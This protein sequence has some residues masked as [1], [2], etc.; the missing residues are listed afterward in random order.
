MTYSKC[1]NSRSLHRSQISEDLRAMQARATAFPSKRGRS[2]LRRARRAILG[3]L[4]VTRDDRETHCASNNP[5]SLADRL[6]HTRRDLG[7]SS[8][9]T[10]SRISSAHEVRSTCPIFMVGV[11]VSRHGSAPSRR[12]IYLFVSSTAARNL[13]GQQQAPVSLVGLGIW[14]FRIVFLDAGMETL[15]L[16]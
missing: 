10:L 9:L 4:F 2:L 7:G 1:P 6:T 3:C 11:R 16:V 15:W 5:N 14:I 13:P 8:H 12:G